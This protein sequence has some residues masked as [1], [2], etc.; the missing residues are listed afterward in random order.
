MSPY[1]DTVRDFRC[2]HGERF[3]LPAKIRLPVL[4][5]HDRERYPILITP[6]GSIDNRSTQSMNVEDLALDGMTSDL[7]TLAQIRQSEQRERRKLHS[8]R[9]QARQLYLK[10]I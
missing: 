9:L 4:L 2:L 6:I 1:R 10:R 5:S 3:I 8:T 7:S